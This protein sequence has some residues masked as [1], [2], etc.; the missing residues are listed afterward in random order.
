MPMTTPSRGGY[1]M[2]AQNYY[3]QQQQ[4][5][6]QQH[7]NVYMSTDHRHGGMAANTHHYGGYG[8]NNMHP[9]SNPRMQSMHYPSSYP[10]MGY[11]P[12]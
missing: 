11:Q 10:V 2:N 7:H 4:Q 8:M 6:Q 5:Q 9:A 12:Q 1:D 3:Y